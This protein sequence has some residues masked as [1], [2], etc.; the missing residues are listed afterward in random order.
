MARY[1][2]IDFFAESMNVE[3]LHVQKVSQISCAEGLCK[4][5]YNFQLSSENSREAVGYF[6]VMS[7]SYIEI[8]SEPKREVKTLDDFKISW[9]EYH[10]F[11]LPNDVNDINVVATSSGR[12]R[13]NTMIYPKIYVGSKDAIRALEFIFKSLTIYFYIF[14][15]LI[16]ILLGVL[17]KYANLESGR[18]QF[19]MIATLIF[20]TMILYSHSVDVVLSVIVSNQY[21]IDAF[22]KTFTLLSLSLIL[23][24]DCKR[25]K[26]VLIFSSVYLILSLSTP[27]NQKIAY[28][29]YKYIAIGQCLL[30]I[31]KGVMSNLK[32]QRQF[33]ILTSFFMI[34]DLGLIFS[35]FSYDSSIYI[36]P[37]ILVSLF[38]VKFYPYLLEIISKSDKVR[39]KEDILHELDQDKLISETKVSEKLATLFDC[40]RVSLCTLKPAPIIYSFI[41]GKGCDVIKD[42]VI[43]SVFA[44]VVQSKCEFWFEKS[45]NILNIKDRSKKLNTT[46]YESEYFVTL[47][48]IVNS[49]VVACISFTEF[50]FIDHYL[51]NIYKQ[52]Q[53]KILIG[54]I[55][56]AFEKY[57]RNLY[58]EEVEQINEK[59]NTMLDNYFC[60]VDGDDEVARA[61]EVINRNY[62]DVSGLFLKYNTDTT[63]RVETSFSLSEDELNSWREIPFK[64]V[65]SNLTSPLAVAINENKIVFINNIS[66]YYDI[67]DE[68]SIELARKYNYKSLLFIPIFFKEHVYGVLV[69]RSGEPMSVRSI[70]KEIK[71]LHSIINMNYHQKY[72][73]AK[74]EE[75]A[76]KF[77]PEHIRTKMLNNED[78]FEEDHGLLIMI[79]LRMSTKI[80][81]NSTEDYDSF[82]LVVERLKEFVLTQEDK[83]FSVQRI[84]WDAFYITKSA[85]EIEDVWDESLDFINNCFE[86]TQTEY[87]DR[88]QNFMSPTD[89]SSRTCLYFGDISRDLVSGKTTIWDI[90]GA[91]M[92]AVCKM[93]QTCKKI[94]GHLYATDI[95][96]NKLDHLNWFDSG[97]RHEATEEKIYTL[98][99]LETNNKKSIA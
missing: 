69:L 28:S 48:I 21:F 2:V 24:D 40:Q 29:L 91:A 20:V 3:V 89:Y 68:L 26:L 72:I 25:N 49:E 1:T 32:L 16:V 11:S 45:R 17:L 66:N 44:R 76:N 98:D 84:E 13:K 15:G 54:R 38:V 78:T 7:D 46:D 63:L 37:K 36:T 31:R 27:E 59:S 71:Q 53:I 52:D 67:L 96:V 75:L 9:F 94:E 85:K 34:H 65:R 51:E 4:R 86:I 5:K 87:L 56:N 19:L 41:E 70:D 12:A 88:F 30:F 57:Y 43:P 62:E 77:V 99:L 10:S 35:L 92:A 93:E 82:M 6:N 39:I 18:K 50:K 74:N 83:G 95:I 61:Y 73:Q 47:P 81:N 8:D 79:D 64:I 42:G 55:I 90:T 97:R 23:V 58:A 60:S 14:L 33:Y 80:T 22:I